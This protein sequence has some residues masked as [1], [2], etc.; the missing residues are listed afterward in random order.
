VNTCTTRVLPVL[1]GVAAVL[2]SAAAIAVFVD[3]VRGD[4]GGADAGGERGPVSAGAALPALPDRG[5]F[6]RELGRG[7]DRTY[8]GVS[9]AVADG[10]PVVR[11][12]SPGS[13]ADDAGLRAGDVIRA[14][15]GRTVATVEE[16][17]ELVAV[18]AAGSRYRLEVTRDGAVQTLEVEQATVADVLRRR[19][20]RAG[21]QFERRHL[22]PSATLSGPGA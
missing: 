15:D 10:A 7:L 1:A 11:A 12:V 14:V 21:K 9:V 18:V 13:P 8:L 17:R 16:L 19:F 5:T 6:A 20:E 2:V 22:S 4:P 3:A